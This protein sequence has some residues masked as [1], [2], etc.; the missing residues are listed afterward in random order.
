TDPAIERN[1][2]YPSR[3]KSGGRGVGIHP[4]RLDVDRDLGGDRTVTEQRAGEREE[5]LPQC[6]VEQEAAKAGAVDEQIATDRPVTS[7]QNRLD[8]AVLGELDVD[9]LGCYMP[10][11]ALDG[12]AP[13]VSSQ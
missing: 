8:P 7:R 1:I 2:P 11:T 3:G 9:H 13:Q 10:S 5:R 4:R 12:I 6:L